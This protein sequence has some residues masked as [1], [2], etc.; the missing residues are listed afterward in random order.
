[1]KYIPLL[2]GKGMCYLRKLLNH[3]RWRL[4]SLQVPT[5][6]FTLTE[7]FEGA[8]LT[9]VFA[10]KPERAFARIRHSQLPFTSLRTYHPAYLSRSG[11]WELISRIVELIR[12]EAA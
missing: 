6:T 10:D 11:Q 5:T 8:A 7:T 2:G 4:Y 3:L 1:M 12:A 9:P